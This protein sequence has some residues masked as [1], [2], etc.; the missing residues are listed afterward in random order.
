MRGQRLRFAITII[1][2]ILACLAYWDTFQ[3]WTMSDDDR[4][5]LAEKDPGRL[6]EME[7][8]SIRLGLD[9]Q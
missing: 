1:I 9:L 2:V 6:L 5:E 8:K 7:Q 4:T 3:L